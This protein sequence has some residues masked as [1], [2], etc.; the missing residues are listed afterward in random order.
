MSKTDVRRIRAGLKH[1]IIDADGHWAEFHPHMRQEFRRIGGDI[2]VGLSTW[3][4]RA[5]RKC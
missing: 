1:P 4:R 2:A 5:F 3:R